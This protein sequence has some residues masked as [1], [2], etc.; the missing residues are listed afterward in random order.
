MSQYKTLAFGEPPLS[1]SEGDWSLASERLSDSP[2]PTS[3][4]DSTGN[5]KQ[6][7]QNTNFTSERLSES[8]LPQSNESGLISSQT[9]P[10]VGELL[11]EMRTTLKQG[12]DKLVS[13]KESETASSGGELPSELQ[14]NLPEGGLLAETL[15]M[16]NV[17]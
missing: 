13:P 4:R 3:D 2:A 11:N 9:I 8:S 16:K 5:R 14:V 12:D 1:E 15:K 7:N 10:G 17:V 6:T